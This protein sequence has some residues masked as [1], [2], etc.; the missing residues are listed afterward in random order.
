[1]PDVQD[2][3]SAPIAAKGSF[4]GLALNNLFTIASK[5]L[6]GNED[7]LLSGSNL[8]LVAYLLPNSSRRHPLLDSAQGSPDAIN[9]C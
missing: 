4:H 7:V 1:M 9:R 3:W 6:G 2:Q 8:G 5:P